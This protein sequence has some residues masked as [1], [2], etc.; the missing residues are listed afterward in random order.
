LPP[1]KV[2]VSGDA[3]L[4]REMEKLLRNLRPDPVEG[5]ERTLGPEAGALASRIAG[6]LLPRL[7]AA[8]ATAPLDLANYVR[9]ERGDA[10]AREEL[11]D[12]AGDVDRLRDEAE[13]IAARVAKLKPSRSGGP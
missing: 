6:T 9:D 10:V 4:A 2:A 13:R 5:I 12:F 11:E 8:L 7:R 3:E 1:G